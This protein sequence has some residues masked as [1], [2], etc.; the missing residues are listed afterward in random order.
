MAKK[1]PNEAERLE[2]LR[3]TTRKRLEANHAYHNAESGKLGLWWKERRAS[4]RAQA[5]A[6]DAMA[7]VSV[8]IVSAL[9]REVVEGF[10]ESLDNV[11]L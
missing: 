10:V 4:W 1:Y 6:S 9:I 3:E 11:D 2:H 7:I 5:A 8:E